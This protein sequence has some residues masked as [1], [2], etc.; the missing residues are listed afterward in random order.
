M[1]PEAPQQVGKVGSLHSV[2]AARA[3]F[4]RSSGMGCLV[5]Q[6]SA[7]RVSRCRAEGRPEGRP[8]T[9]VLPEGRG[10]AAGG[11]EGARAQCRPWSRLPAAGTGAKTPGP[12]APVR[13]RDTLCTDNQAVGTPGVQ[14]PLHGP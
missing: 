2:D 1:S 4:P 11:R 14:P 5:W 13:P 7:V 6:D 10:R 9:G 3:F 12:A 8:E